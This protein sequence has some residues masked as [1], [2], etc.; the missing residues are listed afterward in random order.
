M[1]S[2]K[3]NDWLQVLGL[4]GVMASLVFL[5]LQM[6]QTQEIALAEA[7]STRTSITTDFNAAVLGGPQYYSGMAKLYS[8]LRDELDAE[9]YIALEMEGNLQLFIFENLHYQ[10]SMGFLPESHWR[11][12]L[13]DL[14]CRMSEPFY[15]VQATAWT[16]REDFREVLNESIARGEAAA[17]SCWESPRN[18][19]W[20]YFHRVESTVLQATS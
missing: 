10:Y 4:F 17:A 7:Y 13:A 12:N 6:K 5:G 3:L 1:N 14:D 20:P 19:P 8:G 15:R 18:D 11:K 2:A 9:E 16:T